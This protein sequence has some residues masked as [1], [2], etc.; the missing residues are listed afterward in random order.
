MTSTRIGRLINDGRVDPYPITDCADQRQRK[1]HNDD[2]DSDKR[3]RGT[4]QQETEANDGQGRNPKV[5]AA[6]QRLLKMLM[7][8]AP[9][10]LA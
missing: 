6:H 3:A 7:S 5:T 8:A 2:G 1:Y 9:L 10:F 4:A